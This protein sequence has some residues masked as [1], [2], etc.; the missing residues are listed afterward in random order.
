MARKATYDTALAAEMIKAGARTSEIVKMI[1]GSDK[2]KIW[3]LRGRLSGK[4][5]CEKKLNKFNPLDPEALDLHKPT[6][7]EQSS[8]ARP[9]PK[10]CP[11]CSMH[12]FTESSNRLAWHCFTCGTVLQVLHP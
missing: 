8:N 9:F 11:K 1:P 7:Q 5:S 6:Y 3:C 4:K 10:H 12:Y 2:N